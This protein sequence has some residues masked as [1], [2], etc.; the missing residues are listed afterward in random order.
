MFR[1]RR[2]APAV[3]R[4]FNGTPAC[5]PELPP[6]SRQMDGRAAEGSTASTLYKLQRIQNNNIYGGG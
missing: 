4:I 6:A 5:Q 2:A 1:I 3:S